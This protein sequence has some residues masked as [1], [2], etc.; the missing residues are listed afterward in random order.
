MITL[1]KNDVATVLDDKQWQEAQRTYPLLY[2]A[3]GVV[4]N[5]NGELLMMIKRGK[6]DLPK[7]TLEPNEPLEHC[8]LREVEEE[9]GI[10]GLTIITFRAFTY[11]TYIETDGIEYLKKTHW[12]DMTCNNSRNPQPQAE[13]DITQAVWANPQQVQANLQNAYGSIKELLVQNK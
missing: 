13:E 3:G 12:Y 5:P 4:R 8:A 11:H 10:T 7:G 9:C 2:A 1:Y 6:W